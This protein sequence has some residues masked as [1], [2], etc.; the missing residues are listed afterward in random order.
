MKLLCPPAHLPHQKRKDE[1]NQGQ[2]IAIA[3]ILWLHHLRPSSP[4]KVTFQKN[5][6]R[7]KNSISSHWQQ[8]NAFQ[9]PYVS[10]SCPLFQQ[11]HH[12][13]GWCN[14]S[15]PSSPNILTKGTVW[16]HTAAQRAKKSIRSKDWGNRPEI[17]ITMPLQ[18][19]LVTI[20]HNYSLQMECPTPESQSPPLPIRFFNTII[21]SI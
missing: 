2:P 6:K 15:N 14:H 17:K 12:S 21:S 11:H 10:Q 8:I 19:P 13:S 1:A 9:H 16:L 4:T 7:K 3:T 20:Q 5:I 18:Q